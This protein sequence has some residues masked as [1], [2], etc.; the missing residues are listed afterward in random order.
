VNK[1]ILAICTLLLFSYPASG[2]SLD[3]L[4]N[5][6]VTR[7]TQSYQAAT[8]S[9]TVQPAT[10]AQCWIHIRSDRQQRLAREI[11]ETLM[12]HRYQRGTIEWKPIQKVDTGPQRSQLR[13]FKRQD[14]RQAQE[15][16]EVLRALIPQIELSDESAK[17]ENVDW[18]KSGH[19]ELWLAPDL[20]RLQRPQ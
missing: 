3:A 13:Y 4:I 17:Y 1:I 7:S 14:Q 6:N 20:K 5:K 19:Y 18:I 12:K 15:I 9:P 16:F 10:V 2:G 8:L 11:L